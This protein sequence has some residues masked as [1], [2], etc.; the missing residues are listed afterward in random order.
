M[1]L[2]VQNIL[3]L[4]HQDRQQI[5]LLKRSPT[6]KLFPSLV[7]GV[8]GK[9]EV[10]KGE[11]NNLSASVFREFTEET[12]I[13]PETVDDLRLRLVTTRVGDDE[14]VVLLWYTGFLQTTPED[15]SCNEG[16]LFFIDRT[17]LDT[18]N[19]VPSARD[20]IRFVVALSDADH[21]V[22]TAVY[23]RDM[24]LGLGVTK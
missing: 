17:Q 14:V 23:D 12:S 7:T 22:Y 13:L 20:P 9:V 18:L 3:V 8:G 1:Q 4:H 15:L 10:D 19:F 24:Q 5:L 2:D 16:E 11:A 6:K 21:V